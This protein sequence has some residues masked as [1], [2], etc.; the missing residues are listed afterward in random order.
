MI[1][2]DV[3]LPNCYSEIERHS[4]AETLSDD[5][6]PVGFVV[7]AAREVEFSTSKTVALSA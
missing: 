2:C 4:L 3:Q 5:S 1:G 6:V 7:S